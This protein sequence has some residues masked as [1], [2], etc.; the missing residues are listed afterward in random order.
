[1]KHKSPFLFTEFLA[2]FY[3]A[4]MA[5]SACMG[6]KFIDTPFGVMSGASLISPLW[7]ITG[8]IVAEVYGFKHVMRFFWSV[9][10]VQFVFAIIVTSI[11][12]FKALTPQIDGSYDLIFGHMIKMSL[13]QL[14]GIVIAWR[15]NAVLLTKWKIIVNGKYFW[16]RSIGASGIGEIMYSLIAVSLTLLGN[17]SSQHLIQIV[18]WSCVLKLGITIILSGPANF[19][20]YLLKRAE[21]TDVYEAGHMNPLMKVS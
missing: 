7:F 6:A 2:M 13:F 18:A 19:V 8:D 21:G 5:Y 4:S 11:I 14:I 3:M 12:H 20:C 16:L 15:V 1:M 10:I 9:V 17:T